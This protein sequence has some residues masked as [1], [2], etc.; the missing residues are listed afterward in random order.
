MNKDIASMVSNA[1]ERITLLVAL[2]YDPSAQIES[3][4][5]RLK[6]CR[7]DALYAGQIELYRMIC[8]KLELYEAYQKKGN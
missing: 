3:Y 5:G 6:K 1:E 2:G 4:V 8:T 7:S